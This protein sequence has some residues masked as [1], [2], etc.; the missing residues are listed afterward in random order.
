[1]PALQPLVP[2]Q[3]FFPVQQFFAAGVAESGAFAGGVL[4]AQPPSTPS[5]IPETA[6]AA[7][8]LPIF[9]WISPHPRMCGTLRAVKQEPDQPI[10]AIRAPPKKVRANITEVS[11]TSPLFRSPP[12]SWG[13]AKKPHP[14]PLRRAGCAPAGS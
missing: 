7:K 10:S 12:R 9:I 5:S 14:E 2:L 6:D 8:A 1:M 3:V 11:A 13:V 4:S